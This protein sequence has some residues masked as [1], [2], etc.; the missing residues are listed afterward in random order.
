M[1][2]N[3]ILSFLIPKN[4]L[5]FDLFAEDTN[6]L[7]EQSKC[8]HQLFSAKTPDEVNKIIQQVQD[9]EHKGDE[10]T[11]KIF[12]EL[13]ANFITPFDRE[14]IHFLASSI[15]DIADYINGSASRIHLY[16][17]TEFSEPMRKLS[18]IIIKQ[19]EEIHTAV[20]SL[21]GTKGIPQI[22]D[23]I[24]KINSLENEADKVFD[25]AIAN[26]FSNESNAVKLIKEK[27][28]LS[29]LETATD[30]CEDVAHAL[31]SILVKTS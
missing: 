15:D 16:N 27:E 21:K 22:K 25:N 24:V 30:K 26:L 29:A 12:L 14:D 28:V 1:R 5:F 23:A 10:I 11:H 17:V 8:F 18:E 3:N 13:S 31:E 20:S 4:N 2:L 7:V 9:F 19:A 6:N